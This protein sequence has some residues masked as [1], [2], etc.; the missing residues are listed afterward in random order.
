M[1]ELK[2]FF[3]LQQIV[4]LST[5]AN[6]FIPLRQIVLFLTFSSKLVQ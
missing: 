5:S 2:S 3:Q 1:T 6:S 4:V